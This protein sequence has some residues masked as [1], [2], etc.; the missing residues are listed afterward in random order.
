VSIKYF[1]K[2]ASNF[3]LSSL[4]IVKLGGKLLKIVM[5]TFGTRLFYER[6]LGMSILL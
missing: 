5:P 4:S 2:A 3:A 6:C 1:L